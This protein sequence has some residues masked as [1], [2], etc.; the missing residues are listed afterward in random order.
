VDLPATSNGRGLWK[1]T[2]GISGVV[3]YA[4]AFGKAASLAHA[5]QNS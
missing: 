1:L 2:I 5:F 3:L 4:Y